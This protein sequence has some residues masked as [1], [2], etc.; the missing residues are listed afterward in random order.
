MFSLTKIID[1]FVDANLN[2]LIKEVI[3][4]IEVSDS[5]APQVRN[6]L[7][8]VDWRFRL[9][10]VLLSILIFPEKFLKG[11]FKHKSHSRTITA[12]KK[13][14]LVKSLVQLIHTISMMIALREKC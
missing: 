6:H 4:F 13:L 12:L 10:L 7:I 14:P 3:G 5:I 2:Y 9:A 1:S 8:Q 11:N